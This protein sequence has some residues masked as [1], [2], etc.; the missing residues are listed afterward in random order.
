MPSGQGPPASADD[1]PFD[2]TPIATAEL[3]ATPTRDRN[4]AASAWVDAP[5]RL[6]ELGDGLDLDDRFREAAYKRRI[7]SWLL[8]RI[9]PA[10]GPA[11]Y[12]AVRADDLDVQCEFTLRALR[13]G[14]GVMPDGTAVDRFRDWKQSLLD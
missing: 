8:W 5:E 14:E 4:I 3:P 10:K 9:G 12:L 1:R 11:R 6:L 7:G 13:D 2:H